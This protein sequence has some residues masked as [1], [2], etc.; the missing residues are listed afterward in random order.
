MLTKS[1]RAPRPRFA[2]AWRMAAMSVVILQAYVG[3]SL[4]ARADDLEGQRVVDV[5]LITCG[6]FVRMPIG[7]ALVLV[8]WVGGFFAGRTNDTK[9]EMLDF[10]DEAERVISLCRENQ[11][12]RLMTFVDEDWRRR[13]QGGPRSTAP[14][15]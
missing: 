13:Q 2:R 3:M 7:Q 11:S 9:V 1:I 5:S 14:H 4:S 8:G 12:M 15:Q 6:E 10:I